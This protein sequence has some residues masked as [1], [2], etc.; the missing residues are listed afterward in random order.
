MCVCVCLC[1][2]GRFDLWSESLWHATLAYDFMAAHHLF[3]VAYVRACKIS[4]SSHTK[5]IIISPRNA[6]NAHV[7]VHT[8]SKWIDEPNLNNINTQANAMKFAVQSVKYI[9][10]IVI[11]IRYHHRRRKWRIFGAHATDTCEYIQVYKTVHTISSCYPRRTSEQ[12]H[13]F[14]K[15]AMLFLGIKLVH[16][17]I[18]HR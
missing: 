6:M 7:C 17:T 12:N 13:I 18:L 8:I 10:I 3:A 5:F 16:T 1:V 4:W 15:S 9:L 2:F 14:H 11:R